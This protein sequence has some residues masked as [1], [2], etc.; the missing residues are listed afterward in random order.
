MAAT[1]GT[2][3]LMMTCSRKRCPRPAKSEMKS[4][5]GWEPGSMRAPA[6]SMNQTMG[7]RPRRASSRIRETLTSPVSP[8]DPPLTV[9][10]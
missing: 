3:P 1:W 4:A 5:F 6:E 2:T 9:K 7:Q 10:S 8:I